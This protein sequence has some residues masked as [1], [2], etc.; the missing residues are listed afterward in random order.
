MWFLRRVDRIPP[1]LI[2]LTSAWA[3]LPP[4]AIAGVVLATDGRHPWGPVGVLWAGV[5]VAAG[6]GAAVYNRTSGVE[7]LLEGCE[8]KAIG[9][10]TFLAASRLPALAGGL[11]IAGAMRFGA[12]V[13]LPEIWASPVAVYVFGAVTVLL[14]NRAVVPFSYALRW[15]E[16]PHAHGVR[17]TTVDLSRVRL[18]VA[19]LAFGWVA[20]ALVAMVVATAFW[21]AVLHP[22]PLPP[23]FFGVGVAIFV[24]FLTAAAGFLASVLFGWWCARGAAWL[25]RYGRL[26]IRASS[27]PVSFS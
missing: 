25:N 3:F 12:G 21:L 10:D 23:G 20:L 11:V 9:L 19:A 6:A 1:W 17:I 22:T 13:G 24:G 2:A 18:V 7:L 14:Y 15:T 8:L 16:E 26:E 27:R 4:A 5:A